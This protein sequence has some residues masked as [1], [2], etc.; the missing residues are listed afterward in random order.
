M[1]WG[2]MD[3]RT[4]KTLEPWTIKLGVIGKELSQIEIANR[5]QRFLEERKPV[6]FRS[7]PGTGK[8]LPAV[9]AMVR[10]VRDDLMSGKPILY[11]T[12][13]KSLQK[14][15]LRRLSNELCYF[16]DSD[17]KLEVYDI[18]GRKEIPC[19]WLRAH[20]D[21]SATATK[22]IR[23][24]CPLYFPITTRSYE[25]E[26]L[27]LIAKWGQRR[28]YGID[29]LSV[30]SRDPS[31]I[32]SLRKN[33]RMVNGALLCPY[34]AQYAALDENLGPRIIVT[35]YFKFIADVSTGKYDIDNIAGFIIDEAELFL[36]MFRP[37]DTDYTDLVY[38]NQEI[39]E[40]LKAIEREEVRLSREG[41]VKKTLKVILEIFNEIFTRV[42]QISEGP[43]SDGFI[44]LGRYDVELFLELIR[45]A[46]ELEDA[47]P[48]VA[49]FIQASIPLD[50]KQKHMDIDLFLTTK[51]NK[52]FTLI[53]IP[54]RLRLLE[55][56]AQKPLVLLVGTPDYVTPKILNIDLNKFTLIEGQDT[57]PGRFVIIPFEGAQS[58][59]GIGSRHDK[60]KSVIFPELCRDAF[61]LL[62]KLRGILGRAAVL[63]FAISKKYVEWCE[64][65]TT[66]NAYFD[67]GRYPIDDL[68]SAI[69]NGKIILST[70]LWRGIN[71]MESRVVIF[72]PKFPRPE[73]D[74]AL[75][76]TFKE[77][78]SR[79]IQFT[80]FILSR[81]SRVGSIDSE[82]D[83]ANEFGFRNLYQAIARGNRSPDYVSFLVS[84]DVEAYAAASKLVKGGLLPWPYVLVLNK[85]S[86]ARVVRA[87]EAEVDKL[88]IAFDAQNAIMNQ[89][90]KD[91]VSVWR[92]RAEDEGI[93]L[94]NFLSA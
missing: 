60:H 24:S 70:R 85:D 28:L 26:N 2:W 58:L 1:T 53:F 93:P 14:D 22:C 3:C 12:P 59:K 6:I 62:E 31:I 34:L 25:S 69:E 17:Q 94:G 47:F 48:D 64:N 55:E 71:P 16:I 73:L 92:K 36:D 39:K 13:T 37:R 33:V 79:G 5:I 44:R 45:Q 68:T 52:A 7:A 41:V 65:A 21:L 19:P 78:R 63:G 11:L 75:T 56:L 20:M 88:S 83:L 43:G 27:K 40:R 8:T 15:L 18:L 9:E 84:I 49:E 10:V 82:Y 67:N 30:A 4:G 57:P 23:S 54:R 35:N 77:M 74:P 46:A 90:Y 89:T 72:I 42:R 29:D 50:P 80:G 87:T 91:V 66:I 32:D 81:V 51:G 38:I 76:V 86:D 61:K